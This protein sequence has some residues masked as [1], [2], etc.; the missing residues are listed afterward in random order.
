MQT[1]INIS[2]IKTQQQQT[3]LKLT[4][5]QLTKQTN[6]TSHVATGHWRYKYRRSQGQK[7]FPKHISS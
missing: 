7:T 6:K 4:H 1:Q 3:K 5:N 2:I